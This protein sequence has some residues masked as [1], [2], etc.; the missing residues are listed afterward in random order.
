VARQHLVTPDGAVVQISEP[1]LTT[2]Q[3]LVP[4]LL[5]VPVAAYQ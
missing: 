3:R 5:G 1:E 4:D 2:R